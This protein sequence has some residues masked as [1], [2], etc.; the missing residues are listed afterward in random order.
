VLNE[1]SGLYRF[2]QSANGIGMRANNMP[3]I[4][5]QLD[6]RNVSAFKVLLVSQVLIRGDEKIKFRFS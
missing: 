4:C 6:D 3:I 2:E 5:G 1:C